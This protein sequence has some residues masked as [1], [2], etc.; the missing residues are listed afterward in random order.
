MG[1]SR[2]GTASASVTFCTSHLPKAMALWFQ[3]LAAA[4]K[5][6]SDRRRSMEE[7]ELP[8][9]SPWKYCIAKLLLL[10]SNLAIS[11]LLLQLSS[12]FTR[13]WATATYVGFCHQ[14]LPCSGLV[15]LQNLTMA[16]F[17]KNAGP[18]P[19]LCQDLP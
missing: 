7:S 6:S 1:Q 11:S 8:V 9:H 15:L 18:C 13:I 12:F 17:L 3:L 4:G 5:I 14:W 19:V 16:V 10:P 2:K